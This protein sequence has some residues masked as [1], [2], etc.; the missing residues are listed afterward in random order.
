VQFAVV[1]V[2]VVDDDEG[3]AAT[4]RDVRRRGRLLGW[5]HTPK[6]KAQGGLSPT[7]GAEVI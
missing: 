2:D 5:L 7:N 4:H 1:L 3:F 6:T